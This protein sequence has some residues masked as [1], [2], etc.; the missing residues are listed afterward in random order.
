MNYTEAQVIAIVNEARAEAKK[1]ATKF[2]QEKLGGQDQFACGFAWVEIYGIRA[3]SKI[4]K[5]LI[6]AGV[7]RDPYT[8]TLKIWNPS[9]LNC[10]NIDTKEAGAYAAAKVLEGYGF[11]AYADSRLD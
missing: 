1:Q 7:R 8:K 5:A 2:F 4:G 9:D 3:N 10:Q 6:A 11:R